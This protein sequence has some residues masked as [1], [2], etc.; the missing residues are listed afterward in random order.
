MIET[1]EPRVLFA[2]T[3]VTM[4][5]TATGAATITSTISA[6]TTGVT[7]GTTLKSVSTL[8]AVSNTTYSNLKITGQVTL[9]KLQNVTFSN[10]VIDANGAPWAIRSDYASNI[11]I[12]NC[13]LKNSANEAV[14][15]D[16]YTVTSSYIHDSAGDGFKAR[17]NVTIQGNYITRLGTA[18]DAHADGVQI[19]GGANIRI[20]GNYF[21]MPINVAGTNSNTAMFLQG[22]TS[23]VVFAG[24]RVRGGNYSIHAYSDTSNTSIKIY[25]NT[26]I[27]GSPR[28][29]FGHLGTGVVWTQNINDKGAVALTTSR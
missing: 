24:N 13:E 15:G 1:V 17:N 3:L 7:P 2:A 5:S 10:C 4:S 8:K 14:Y 26:F 28:Y 21:N 9:T 12:K 19:S 23:D 27:T 11:Q 20:L 22:A 6:T 18:A 25:S 29:A 16:G